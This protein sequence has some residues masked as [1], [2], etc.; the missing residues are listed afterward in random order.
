MQSDIPKAAQLLVFP[1][2]NNKSHIKAF[3]FFTKFYPSYKD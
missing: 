2:I 3:I 1:V